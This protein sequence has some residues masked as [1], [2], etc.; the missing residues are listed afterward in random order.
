MVYEDTANCVSFI[1]SVS[2]DFNLRL[3][4]HIDNTHCKLHDLFDEVREL[5]LGAH[6]IPYLHN[7]KPL[8]I[9]FG[10][11]YHFIWGL[12]EIS[13]YDKEELLLDFFFQRFDNIYVHFKESS[14]MQNEVLESSTNI[15]Y[16]HLD[17]RCKIISFI[18]CF[19]E[20]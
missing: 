9:R 15:E 13:H 7:W 18:L 8:L 2:N 4:Y 16:L 17:F 3:I 11:R 10:K 1:N 19:A 5:D 20:Q 12:F 6:K 14:C